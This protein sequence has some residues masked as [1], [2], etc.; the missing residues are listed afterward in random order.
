MEIVKGNSVVEGLGGEPI[1]SED[2]LSLLKGK[3]QDKEKDVISIHPDTSKR[4]QDMIR[5]IRE[6]ENNI[7]IVYSTML[8]TLGKSGQKYNFSEDFTKLIEV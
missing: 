4:L 7:R 3:P 5:V 1:E 6:M 8:E 2:G